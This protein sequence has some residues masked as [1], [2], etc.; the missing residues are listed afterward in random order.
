MRYNLP[1]LLPCLPAVLASAF[2]WFVSSYFIT[3]SI[4]LVGSLV[5]GYSN[6]KNLVSL[7]ASK[8]L[9]LATYYRPHSLHG[10][11][12]SLSESLWR[13]NFLVY[14]FIV[15]HKLVLQVFF[16]SVKSALIKDRFHGR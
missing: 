12:K 8:T 15:L 9:H 4:G 16:S 11:K 1:V 13:F 2:E 14:I 5:P 10:T 3:T 7:L 6:E